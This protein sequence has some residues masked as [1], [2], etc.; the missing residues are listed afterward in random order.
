MKLEPIFLLSCAIT[1][2]PATSR[3]VNPSDAKRIERVEAGLTRDVI[4]FA[5][6][7]PQTMSLRERME[8]Y[9]VNGL[10][11][12]V[13]D[14]GEVAWTKTYGVADASS[15]ETLTPETLFQTASMGKLITAVA[16]LQLVK[17]GKITLDE[18]VN[19]KLVSWKVPSNAFTAQQKV[20]LRRLLNHSAG[21]A[22]D[23]GFA[24]Y[25]PGHPVPTLGQ[26]VRHQPPTSGKPVE[27]DL[28]PGSVMRYSGFGY[29]VV[30]QLIED[31]TGRRFQDYVEQEIFRKL[32]MPL[33]TYRFSPDQELGRL[34]ARGHEGNGTIDPSKK[35]H[36]YPEAAAAGFWSTPIELA[37]LLIQL[38]RELKGESTQLLNQALMQTML[39]PQFDSNPRGIG[40][41]LQGASRA[42]GFGHSG[43]NAGYQSVLY[44][45]TATGQG[46]VVMTNSDEGI[47]LVMEV[48]RSIANEYKWPFLQTRLTQTLP[49]SARKQY[50][51]LFH[52]EVGLSE[53]IR[54]NKRGL[55]LQFMEPGQKKWSSPRYL[56]WLGGQRFIIEQAPD[57]LLFTFQLDN[58]GRTQGILFEKYA[59]TKYRFERG[60]KN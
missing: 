25:P 12:A 48:V 41:V 19:D 23:E 17:A 9:R 11:I 55:S 5:G 37:R 60:T 14:K 49:D 27:I 20:T 34:V 46:A 51:G 3:F 58:Q 30:Q 56:H 44:A 32:Q 29:L 26:L 24:G 33:S 28:V 35:Y 42:E 1:I 22:N 50:V 54:E 53:R 10:S 38:Q 40:V 47:E 43:A 7:P 18:D 31:V 2:L 4:R 39:S 6:R 45:T 16:A 8:H 57:D 52:S 15:L 13:I 21:F 59:G 36:V